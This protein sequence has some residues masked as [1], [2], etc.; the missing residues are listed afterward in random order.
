M[1]DLHGKASV[2]VT[3][4]SLKTESRPVFCLDPE[5]SSQRGPRAEYVPGTVWAPAHTTETCHGFLVSHTNSRN[6]LL[7]LTDKQR[8]KVPCKSCSCWL[9]CFAPGRRGWEYTRGHS[10]PPTGACSSRANVHGGSWPA[11][12]LAFQGGTE[13]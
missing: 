12:L 4:T 2:M 8:G 11:P 1:E 7:N 3:P 13:E 10:R 5:Q 6:C 9:S